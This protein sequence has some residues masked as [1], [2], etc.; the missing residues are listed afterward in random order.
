MKYRLI[1]ADRG[2]L[3]VP[4][5]LDR[6]GCVGGLV[7]IDA[8]TTLGDLI[9][10]VRARIREALTHQRVPLSE[11]KTGV[12]DLKTEL[13]GLNSY[14]AAAAKNH[15]PALTAVDETVTEPSA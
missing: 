10:Q 8:D 13:T 5:G 1:D 14:V 9:I 3:A 7:R 12:S 15:L 4:V 6:R 11:I 2:D